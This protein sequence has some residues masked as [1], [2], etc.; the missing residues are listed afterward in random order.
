MTD[1][2]VLRSDAERNRVRLVETAS[3]AFAECGFDVSMDEIARKAGLGKGTIFRRF[4][5]KEHLV[6]AIA[7]ERMGE[8]LE[9]GT[10]LLAEPD[11]GLAMRDFMRSAVA[12]LSRD[13]G[14]TE[15]IHGL[16]CDNIDI[17]EAKHDVLDTVAA[18][19]T[20]AQAQGSIRDDIS[21]CDIM[22]MVAA[23]SRI[24]APF[25]SVDTT[26]WTRYL[27]LVFDGL[28]S[29]SASVLS[30]PVPTDDQ[31]MAASVAGAHR[32]RHKI[33]REP[34]DALT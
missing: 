13:R 15:A 1:I 20:R 10:T 14:L 23:V 6:A 26:I 34:E 32:F 4:P 12:L 33:L 7:C 24:A 29:E 25:S 2:R 28:R 9:T 22:L 31:M 21:A 19:L 16:S 11:A 8:L 18:L 5:T 17:Q 27:D 3:C 30:H